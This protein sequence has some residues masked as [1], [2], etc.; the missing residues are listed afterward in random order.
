[1]TARILVVDDT[2]ANLRLLEAKLTAEY[3]EVLT[4]AD[5]PSA[6]DMAASNAPDLI[7]LDIM[8]PGLDG[9]EVAKRLKSD[10]STQHIPIVMVT[11]LTDS[12]D[13]VR[14]LEAG[15]DDFISKP[16]NDVALFA[17]V[18]SLTRL[19]VMMD[20]LRIRHMATG[21]F[22]MAGKDPYGDDD[23]TITGK[24]LL[25]DD[26]KNMVGQ[27]R[28]YLTDAGHIVEPATSSA[29][30][31]ERSRSGAFD[32]LIVALHLQGEDGLR[33]CSQLRSQEETR[34]VPILMILDDGDLRHLAKGLDLGVTDYLVR[35]IDK[36]ELR[37]RTRTQ[38]RRRRYH[39]RLRNMLESSVSLAYTD[40]L[41][42]V[43]NRRYMDDHL[44]R[45]IEEIAA[46]A[47]PVSVMIF[48]LDHFKRIND[49]YGHACGDRILKGVAERVSTS[50]RD[51]DLVARYG[52]EEFVVIMP[53]TPADV[54]LTVA[55][56]LRN[57]LAEQPFA[58]PGQ[59]DGL[60]VT[61]SIGVATTTDPAETVEGL[62]MRA[63]AALY[64][65]KEAG[66]NQMRAADEVNSPGTKRRSP[67]TVQSA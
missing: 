17:R 25:V 34:H 2:P 51:I 6:L 3:F 65:A 56:R 64:A 28:G 60:A 27:V 4:A 32:L 61:A 33:L 52:G 54:A 62:L 1:M 36:N 45:K 11:A 66:R 57:R 58:V 18:R 16:V 35:P 43:Y 22:Q 15:A 21:R 24:V 63:D 39:D 14:G 42:G 7:L 8:M 46:T 48:D 37:A 53:S 50:I 29:E 49:S 20:E 5:G 47:K 55:D 26:T 19:K 13:R 30:A 9:F 67:E 41:T 31:L 40:T 12:A 38:I 44:A 59:A 23:E 10:P